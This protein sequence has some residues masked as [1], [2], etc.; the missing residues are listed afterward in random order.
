MISQKS[1]QFHYTDRIATAIDDYVQKSRS[2][3]GKGES[4]V[5]EI[6]GWGC[7]RIRVSLGELRSESSRLAQRLRYDPLRHLRALEAACHEIA[8]EERP[9]YDKEGEF[10]FFTSIFCN[11]TF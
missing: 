1:Q 8:M 11:D 4:A 7:P 3:S 10:K 6:L 2:R 9:G 5:G